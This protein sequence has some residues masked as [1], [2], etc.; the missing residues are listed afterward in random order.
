MLYLLDSSCG[1][2]VWMPTFLEGRSDINYT[3]YDLLHENVERARE[4]FTNKT[5]T[6]EEFDLVKGRVSTMFKSL[7]NLISQNYSEHLKL[8]QNI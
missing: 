8:S 5:W 2:M 4:K 6:F 7:H 3:G 1:D